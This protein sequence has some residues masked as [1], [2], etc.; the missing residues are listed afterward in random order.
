M[1][2]NI[3]N[4]NS[5]IDL[6]EIFTL[7]WKKKLILI[8]ITSFFSIS[9][10]FYSLSLDNIYKSSSLVTVKDSSQ[11]QSAGSLGS[12]ASAFTGVSIETPISNRDLALEIITSRDFLNMIIQKHD[13]LPAIAAIKTYDAETNQ[14]IFNE[15]IYNKKTKNWVV[16]GDLKIPTYQD[17]YEIYMASLGAFK[18]ENGFI[19]LSYSH[20]SPFFARDM[21]NIIIS[22]ANILKSSNDQLEISKSI[23]FLKAQ[24]QAASL[25]GVKNT[26][27]TILEDQIE[28]LMMVNVKKEYL[29]EIIDS[30][31]VPEKKDRPSRAL[32][33]V[34]TSL[35]GLFSAFIVI[36]FFNIGV[37]KAP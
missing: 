26:I 7:L 18:T 31:Y 4:A 16:D 22:E 37:R 9:S 8:T 13:L 1:N 28:K 12:L 25:D 35:V 33:V 17:A 27:Y 34:M 2:N 24:S 3:K 30:P 15:Q 11:S 10:I 14:I 6:N 5:E 32:L 29:I 23:E 36:F 20:K 19:D 21:L